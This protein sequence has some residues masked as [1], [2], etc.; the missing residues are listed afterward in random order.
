MNRIHLESV[1]STNSYLRE[2]VQKDPSLSTYTTVTADE[3]TQGR[4][5]KGNSWESEPKKNMT[6]SILLRPDLQTNPCSKNYDLSILVA[7]AV[8][9][10]VEKRLDH[11]EVKVKWPND[12][13]VGDR[14]IAGILIE[15]EFEGSRLVYSIA[16]IGVNINQE[17]FWHYPLPATSLRLESG[18]EQDVN[19]F[20]D[21]LA[22]TI[23]S[24]ADRLPQSVEVYR[25]QYHRHLYR[26]NEP[27]RLYSLPDGTRFRGT[28]THVEP[29]GRLVVKDDLSGELRSYTFKEIRFE[30]E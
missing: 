1:L 27:G 16:G 19:R 21:E 30:Q 6:L 9:D 23:R 4:G 18:R 11:Q 15:N 3:Q 28:L 17:S 25:A 5:Q 8:R 24:M 14:K 22:M 29:D 26:L 13:L 7:L 20:T 10:M 2:L 12:I